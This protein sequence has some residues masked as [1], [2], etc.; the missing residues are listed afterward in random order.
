MKTLLGT[1][2]PTCKNT[3]FT[4]LDATGQTLTFTS[5]NYPSNYGQGSDCYWSVFA[6]NATKLKI[7]ISSFDVSS[8][9][10]ISIQICD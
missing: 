6:P 10:K 2:E 7:T 4:Q 1:S 5:D 8:T 3:G 9:F